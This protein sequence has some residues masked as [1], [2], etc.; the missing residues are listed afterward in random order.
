M[1]LT[2]PRI[3]RIVA[4]VALASAIA[5]VPQA[6]AAS[7]RDAALTRSI[8][9]ALGTTAAPGAIVGVWQQGRAPYVRSFGVRDSA[10]R[11]PMRS[12]LFMRIGSVT[13]TFTVTALLQLVDQGKVALDDPISKYVPGVIS[14]DAITLR[15]LATMRSGLLNYSVVPAFDRLLTDEPFLPWTPRRLLSYAIGEPLLFEPGTGFSYSNTNTILLGMVVEQVSGERLGPY[16]RRHITAPLGMRQTSFPAG[17]RFPAP[18]AQGYA[19]TTPDGRVANATAWDPTWTWSAGQMVSTLR[20]LRIWAPRL[21]S[22]RGL[23]SARTQRLRLASVAGDAPIVYGIG[24]FNVSGWLGHNGSLPGYQTLS[25][26]RP[27]T[28]TTIVALINT[29]IA[30][31]GVAPST[32]VGEA[33]TRV[34]SPRNV[35]SLPAAP[36]SDDDPEASAAVVGGT[37]ASRAQFPAFSV[38]G[39]GC[40][41]TLIAPDRVLT[42]AHCTSALE[43][44]DEVLVGPE[45]ERRTIRRRAILPLHVRELAKME[46]E[47]PPPA[48]DLMILELDRPVRDVP[49]A[50]IATAADGLTRAGTAATTI[51]RGATRSDGS[52]EGVFRSALV[53]LVPPGSC[54]DQLPAA[55]ERRWSLCTRGRPVAGPRGKTV[56]TS[57]CVGDS[58]GPLLAGPA[59][60]ARI[61]GV[62]SWGPSCGEDGDPEIYANAVEGREF[63]LAARPAWAPAVIGRARIT[64]TAAVGRT[65]TCDVR[66]LVK[67]TRDLDY[68][69]TIDG[70]QKQEGPRPTFRLTS[71]HRG[72][73]VSCTAG[74]ATIGGRGGAPGLAPA[75]LVR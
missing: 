62:V 47:F 30:R 19:D 73:R 36:T 33:I 20:D 42:A 53:D 58:G 64:G 37:P 12:D 21:V 65:V 9:Q 29:D 54:D 67:P 31:R 22:G 75:R 72:K 10:T 39:T 63:A 60:S 38:V 52:G 28:K 6:S 25:L 1:Q 15:Q 13:K 48:G 57:A 49:V 8:R 26:Y 43:E 71:E 34:I 7:P 68:G 4:S 16:I 32:L 40:G 50:T 24:M 66:W 17:T 59:E 27:R 5:T 41:G 69:F 55:L 11:R 44:S 45:N 51:G 46:R 70:F 14:G 74:G 18:H 23:L 56:K 61:V 35:Y 3:A 2:S